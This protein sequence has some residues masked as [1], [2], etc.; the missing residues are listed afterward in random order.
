M[1]LS[2]HLF[3]GFGMYTSSRSLSNVSEMNSWVICLALFHHLLSTPPSSTS[4]CIYRRFILVFIASNIVYSI[5]ARPTSALLWVVMGLW[6]WGFASNVSSVAENVF[7]T[8]YFVW[9]N[10]EKYW[11][12]IQLLI[13][14]SYNKLLDQ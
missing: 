4:N 12:C 6:L 7:M 2:F 5:F 1:T 10:S 3:S 11:V 9:S 13:I 14:P 8:R